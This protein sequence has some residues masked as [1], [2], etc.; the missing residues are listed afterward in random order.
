MA[1]TFT[2]WSIVAE[3]STTTALF[4]TRIKFRY[5]ARGVASLSYRTCHGGFAWCAAGSLLSGGPLTVVRCLAAGGLRGTIV[6]VDMRT[7]HVPQ[8]AIVRMIRKRSSSPPAPS[9]CEASTDA[10]AYYA[11]HEVVVEATGTHAPCLT[12]EAAPFPAPLLELL[13]AQFATPTP[14]QAATWPLAVT[15]C[16]DVLAIART[17]SGK[18]LAF[19]LPAISRLTDDDAGTL[20]SA[21][22]QQGPSS[23]L[24]PPLGAP[25]SSGWLHTLT[26]RGRPTGHPATTSIEPAA[27]KQYRFHCV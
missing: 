7:P 23:G 18:T 14:I 24:A 11:R 26:V 1:R 8:D 12:L 25:D 2:V 19:L 16:R 15:A 9:G 27:P 10:Q 5:F 21:F 20:S 17:G 6:E 13:Q 4:M 3:M 22:K